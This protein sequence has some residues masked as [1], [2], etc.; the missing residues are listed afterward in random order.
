MLTYRRASK[1]MPTITFTSSREANLLGLVALAKLTSK[2]QYKN[3]VAKDLLP[4][5]EFEDTAEKSE[6]TRSEA[7]PSVHRI[8]LMYTTV[9]LLRFCKFIG[10]MK[11]R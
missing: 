8:L 1:R 3:I 5:Y 9:T 11:Q 6:G 10:A 7:A 4:R 2:S